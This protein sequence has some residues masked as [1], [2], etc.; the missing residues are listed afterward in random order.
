MLRE[1]SADIGLSISDGHGKPEYAVLFREFLAGGE[2]LRVYEEGRLVFSSGEQR[3]VPLMAYLAGPA[4]RRQ[5]VTIF[6]KIGGNAAALLAV[7]ANCRELF[8]PLGSEI[9]VRTLTKY[10]VKYH[11]TSVVP[12][13]TQP[14][15]K[16]MC[17]ME[18]LSI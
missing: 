13:I 5:P 3:L 7:K 16:S 8:S 12:Y 4:C 10:G 18:K 11:F 14:D 6:D 2:T 17:P 9:A 1:K 15:G